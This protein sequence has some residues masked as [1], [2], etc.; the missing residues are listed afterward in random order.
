MKPSEG[1]RQ[2]KAEKQSKEKTHGVAAMDLNFEFKML[3]NIRV[4]LKY[5][6]VEQSTMSNLQMMDSF[7]NTSFLLISAHC[8]SNF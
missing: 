3:C 6:S 5:G 2:G 8:G 7:V 4:K 1:R